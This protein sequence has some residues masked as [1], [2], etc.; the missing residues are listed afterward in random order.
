[1]PA[2]A[3]L[4]W[5]F[6]LEKTVL[7]YERFILGSTKGKQKYSLNVPHMLLRLRLRRSQCDNLTAEAKIPAPTILAATWGAS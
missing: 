7:H 5:A 1:M 3:N 2:F 4:D 6:G